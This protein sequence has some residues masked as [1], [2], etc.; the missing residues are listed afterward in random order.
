MTRLSVALI[1]L[2][3]VV[4]LAQPQGQV[5]WSHPGTDGIY[6]AVAVSDV[7]GDTMPD[8]VAAIYYG[9]TPSDPRKVYC[10]SGATGDTVWVNRSAYGTWG[11]K[12]LNA[13]ED[14][15]GDG[16]QDIILGTVGTYIPPGRS[17][18]AIDGVSGDTLWVFPF[19]QDRGWCY[20]V[21]PFVDIDG[22][23]FPEVLAS[24]GGVTSYPSGTAIM[25]SGNTG[26]SI[27]AFRPPLD[28][29]QC[30]SPFD[31][32]NG[33]SVPDVVVGAGGNGNDNRIFGL[34]GSNGAQLWSYET[35]NSVQ[36]V[37]M[38]PDVNGSG[39]DDCIAGGWAD[40]VFCLEGSTGAPIWAHSIGTIVMEIVPVRD[41]DGDTL[42]D[43]V[44]GSWGS[45]VVVLSG[46]DGTII[47]TGSIGSDVWAVDTLADVTDD[48][49][50]EVIGG[51]LGG[52]DGRVSVFDGSSGTL[53]W[54]YDFQERV[55]DISG[56]PDLNGDGRADV[57]VGLQ[58]HGNMADHLYAF[59]GVPSS[60]SDEA[61]H[62]YLPRH[63][64]QYEPSR[65]SLLLRI[66]S[67]TEYSVGV[68]DATGRRL[69]PRVHGHQ[70]GTA[71]VRL[72]LDRLC[73]SPPAGACFAQLRLSNGDA[74]TLKLIALTT[75]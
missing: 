36:D 39:T 2:L 1:I 14:L 67:G 33:D 74:A 7:D 30:I 58:D 61:G 26:D 5:L 25:L 13:S 45:S 43:V 64:M 28:G 22:D 46:A 31:D 57:V 49:I 19:G 18:V 48:G 9:G 38:I 55:Y 63:L 72:A 68:F 37:E 60:G 53:L 24:A 42:C 66:P 51:C 23:S 47:W 41:L 69:G 15:S 44:V 16:I 40:T 21:K 17:C 4:A 35:D 27:W 32:I 59:N 62:A 8:V 50:P 10:I 75:R 73:A 54:Y 56:V 52:G 20:T 3:P 29:A 70:S 11:N 34:S 6:S 65:R 71:P 12:G